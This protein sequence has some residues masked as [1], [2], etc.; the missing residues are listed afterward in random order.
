M[1]SAGRVIDRDF[2]I[3][4]KHRG[5]PVEKAERCDVLS[6]P[7]EEARFRSIWLPIAVSVACITGYG[8]SLDAEV[9][10]MFQELVRKG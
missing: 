9:V 10:S 5:I 4:A 3:T 6:F 1:I 8:W 7:I 2:R